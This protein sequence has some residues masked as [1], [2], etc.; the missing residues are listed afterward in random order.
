MSAGR[1]GGERVLLDEPAPC[2]GCRL[3]AE[4][5]EDAAGAVWAWHDLCRARSTGSGLDLLVDAIDQ[6]AAVRMARAAGR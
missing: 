6:H 3:P 2:T 5:G 1:W 4:Y